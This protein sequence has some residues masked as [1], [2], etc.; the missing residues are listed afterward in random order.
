MENKYTKE[1]LA[2]LW[3]KSCDD[4]TDRRYFTRSGVNEPSYRVEL[5]D[6]IS[7][8]VSQRME[9]PT[10]TTSLNTP[11]VP[12]YSVQLIIANYIQYNYIKL[13][14]DEFKSLEYVFIDADGK[15]EKIERE[16]T[17]IS[18]CRELDAMIST[19]VA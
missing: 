1:Q 4:C 12:V 11:K 8:E 16:E 15:L 5:R 6:N 10:N 14:E 7:I 18:A 17:M 3:N 2:G 9:M 13:T 19:W